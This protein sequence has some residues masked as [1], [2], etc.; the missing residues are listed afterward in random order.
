MSDQSQGPGWWQASDGKWYPPE[1]A[2]TG[3]QPVTPGGPPPAAPGGPGGPPPYAAPGAAAAGG[4][5]AGKIIA[6]VV[7][8]LLVVG[9]GVF[10]L[11]RD[12]GGGVSFCDQAKAID[13]NKDLENAFTDPN[14][15]DKALGEVDKLVNAAPS[16]I[17]A[18][19]QTLRDGLKKIVD[20]IKQH[21][22][23]DDAISSDELQKFEDAGN[24]VEA[25][26][27]KK[28][29]P[30]FG[31]SDTASDA[32]SRSS[33]GSSSDDSFSFDSRSFESELSQFSD[34]FSDFFSSDF[35]SSDFF[36]SDFFSSNN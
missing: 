20:A 7:V 5:G 13:Q 16:E 25:F 17:K 24:R 26:G 21:K 23:P 28:C 22:N 12:S 15:A 3:T 8:A 11:T 4:G 36:D 29:G 10:L 14:R 1:Q 19:V 9:G 27:F 34:S 18:D 35:F 31:F 33:S 6:I 30:G 2:A 32:S